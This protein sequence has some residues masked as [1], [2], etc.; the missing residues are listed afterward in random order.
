MDPELRDPSLVVDIHSSSTG[1][2]LWD[3]ERWSGT[4]RILCQNSIDGTGTH[5]DSGTGD[6]ITRN[7][8]DV[9]HISFSNN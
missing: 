5:V 9:I 1:H 8:F 7:C 4:G 3:P 2:I 6:F